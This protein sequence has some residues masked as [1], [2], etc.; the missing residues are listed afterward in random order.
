ML[1]AKKVF[2]NYNQRKRASCNRNNNG[3][4]YESSRGPRRSAIAPADPECSSPAIVPLSTPFTIVSV[5]IISYPQLTLVL[6]FVIY[7][8]P[9]DMLIWPRCRHVRGIDRCVT[10]SPNAHGSPI[11]QGLR[12]PRRKYAETRAN[13]TYNGKINTEN[14]TSG[15][16]ALNEIWI[17]RRSSLVNY[18]RNP[19]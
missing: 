18:E 5:T 9:R 12:P 3:W 1:N 13:K 2:R 10:R 11:A 8:M 6:K 4:R 19:I 16:A 17:T 14:V 7:E 15:S